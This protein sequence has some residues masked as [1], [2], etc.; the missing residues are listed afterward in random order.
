[1]T[2]A[3]AEHHPARSATLRELAI[4][5][6]EALATLADADLP[7]EVVFDT[8]E[9]MQ[10]EI[11]DK[12]DA[13]LSYAANLQALADAREA[14]AERLAESAKKLVGRADNLRTYVQIVLM[15]AG[16]KLPLVTGRWT[17]GL[18]KNPPSCD[19]VDESLV[20]GVY[21]TEHIKIQAPIG[22]GIK[23]LDS[24]GQTLGVAADAVTIETKVDK[25]ALLADLKVVADVN[26][27]R[28][29]SEAPDH[30]PGAR[31]NPTSYRLT[32]K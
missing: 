8:L 15:N 30:I 4:E 29:A 25:R 19:V 12:V 26:S 18:A 17:V 28:S 2:H 13:V 5:Y 10:G 27:R 23:L 32:V 22:A 14:E 7:P 3:L 1:M 24:L 20:P 11:T 21:K 16:L 31:L 6:H 9:G